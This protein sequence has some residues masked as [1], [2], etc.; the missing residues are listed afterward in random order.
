MDDLPL[1]HDVRARET[2]A[3]TLQLELREDEVRRCRADVDPDGPE[4]QPLGRDISAEVI[5]IVVVMTVMS[6]VVR[7]RRG[8]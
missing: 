5:R 2:D 3:L 8:Q 7:M 6:A 1:D 4:A